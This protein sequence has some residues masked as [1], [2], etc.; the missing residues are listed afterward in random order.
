MR[1]KMG[2]LTDFREVVIGL[3]HKK[4]SE[5]SAKLCPKCGSPKIMVSSGFDVYPRLY[6]ITPGLYI[7]AECGYNGPVVMEQTKEE[8]D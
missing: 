4:L 5:P 1:E 3:K 8:T 6:G 7:C 2:I